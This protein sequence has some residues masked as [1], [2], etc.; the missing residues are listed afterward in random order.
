MS[1]AHGRPLIVAAL[2]VLAA[3]AAATARGVGDTPHAGFAV[4][5]VKLAGDPADP[6]TLAHVRFCRELGFN[7]LWV[8]SGEA[9]RWTEDRAP[10]GPRLDPGFLRL[11]RDCHRRGM[12]IW[13]SIN[14]MGDTRE[15]FVFSDPDG[16]RRILEFA[17]LL[18]RKARVRRIVLSFDDQPNELSELSDIFRYGSSAAPAHLDLTRR[19]ARGLPDGVALWLCASAYC[20]AHLGDG[21]SPYA[22]AF[23]RELPSIPREI[24]I[25]WTGPR[26]LSPSITRAELAATRARLGGRRI[27][28]HDNFLVNDYEERNALGLVLAALRGRDPGLRDVVAAYL[29]PPLRPLA[30]SRLTLATSADFLRSPSDYDADTSVARAIRRLVGADRPAATALETQQL[31]WGKPIDRSLE[32][33]RDVMTAGLAGRSLHD[34]ALVDSFTWTA[35]RYPG[36]MA[37]LANLAD[38]AF[39][40]DVLQAMRRRLAIARAMPL[41]IE[42]LARIRA[43]RADAA[44]VLA[45]IDDERRA[46]NGDPGARRVL[47][48]FLD[49]AKVPAFTGSR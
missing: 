21:T 25:V 14:P 37:A 22:H 12:E 40:D 6:R 45:R 20:D 39:R 30:G 15:G 17:R 5:I 24:G 34:P 1:V 46:W 32:G 18:R 3:A 19:I 31:E 11:A 38:T 43:G 7:A 27:L 47:E 26:V 2:V 4:R 42:Y 33:V 41:T 13:V 28:L 16:E 29:S 9:G 23:L 10:H 48:T 35:A 49:A 36:R 8:D 44:E